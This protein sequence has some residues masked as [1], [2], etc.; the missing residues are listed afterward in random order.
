M[1][2]R[3]SAWQALTGFAA[4][5]I[6]FEALFEFAT[7]WSLE[8]LQLPSVRGRAAVGAA[9]GVGFMWAMLGICVLFLRWR[10]QTLAD[11]GWRRPATTRSWWLAV[12][13]VVLVAGGA[14]FGPLGKPAQL[15]SD[16][17][18]YRV[19]LALIMGATAGVCLETMFRGFIMTQARDAGM[20]AVIQITMSAVLCALVLARFAYASYP[21]H[22]DVSGVIATTMSSVVLCAF[23]AVIYVMGRRSLNP[24]I[25]AHAAIDTVVEPG[26]ML[27]SAMGGVV[28]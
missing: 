10:G 21:T 6:I 5:W 4:T 24:A 9:F 15:L 27:L 2:S 1:R 7:K 25:A 20:P 14:L 19:S 26:L 23:F 28:H 18:F 17:S 3:L 16:W 11:I 8:T 13:L 22:P 12:A